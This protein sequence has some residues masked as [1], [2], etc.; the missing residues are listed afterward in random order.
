MYCYV[1]LC[2][3]MLFSDFHWECWT[4]PQQ[5]NTQQDPRASKGPKR[6]TITVL[7]FKMSTFFNPLRF[8]FLRGRMGAHV[9]LSVFSCI[10]VYF[11]T[12]SRIFMYLVCIFTY[13]PIFSRISS[14]CYGIYV[15]F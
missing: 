14:V 7:E 15:V 6:L 5:T 11:Q 13:I 2:I 4:P 9:F 1:S 10:F 8:G 3:L 12:F